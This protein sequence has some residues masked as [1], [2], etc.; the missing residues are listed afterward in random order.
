[1]LVILVLRHRGFLPWDAVHASP[2]SSHVPAVA[3]VTEVLSAEVLGDRA[4]MVS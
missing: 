2:A 4:S 3:P 1:M